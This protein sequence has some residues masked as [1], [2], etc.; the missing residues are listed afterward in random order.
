MTP[1]SVAC[2][3]LAIYMIFDVDFIF[4]L[5]S[6]HH[7]VKSNRSSLLGT[8]HLICPPRLFTPHA[9][10]SCPHAQAPSVWPRGGPSMPQPAFKLRKTTICTYSQQSLG[11]LRLIEYY[12]VEVVMLKTK[13]GRRAQ[14]LSW[15]RALSAPERPNRLGCG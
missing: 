3:R 2:V 9:H 12:S 7:S 15:P 4:K 13:F 1:A 14:L 11:L 8:S 6:M 10:R 5:R